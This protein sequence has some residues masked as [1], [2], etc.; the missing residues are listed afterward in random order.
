MAEYGQ[1]TREETKWAK[2]ALERIVPL[3]EELSR[4]CGELCGQRKTADVIDACVVIVAREHQ[5]AIVTGDAAD[6]RRLD[7]RCALIEV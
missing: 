4:A 1:P 6:L 2:S 5:D 3:D 7:P